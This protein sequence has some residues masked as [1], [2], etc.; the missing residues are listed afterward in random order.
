MFVPIGKIPG[1]SGT[2]FKHKKVFKH[3]NNK[4]KFI[5]SHCDL[6][7]EER[8]ELKTYHS[9]TYYKAFIV[10]SSIATFLILA[11][12]L[13][14]RIDKIQVHGGEKA[15]FNEKM[16]FFTPEE[17]SYA[18]SLYDIALINY[19]NEQ[20]TRAHEKLYALLLVDENNLPAEKLLLKVLDKKCRI[21]NV[22]CQ[23]FENY[24]DALN[25]KYKT[26]I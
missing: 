6:V 24:T 20:Y 8:E 25:Y 23:D 3:L 19:K 18:Q 11:F 12:Q 9:F 22:G 14:N 16:D 21:F 15:E 2:D 7:L 1:H 4:S 17:L 13:V 5:T 10:L 26:P